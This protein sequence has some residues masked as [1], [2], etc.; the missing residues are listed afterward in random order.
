MWTYVFGQNVHY[1]QD[2]KQVEGKISTI[3]YFILASMISMDVWP[4][5]FKISGLSSTHV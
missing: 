1:V 2:H 3:L 5:M 4:Q